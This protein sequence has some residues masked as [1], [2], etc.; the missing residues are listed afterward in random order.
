[1]ATKANSKL[2]NILKYQRAFHIPQRRRSINY[3]DIPLQKEINQTMIL[4][5]IDVDTKKE[6]KL[7]LLRNGYHLKKKT[8]I[9]GIRSPVKIY[10]L[11]RGDGKIKFSI[12]NKKKWSKLSDREQK[13]AKQAALGDAI[14]NYIK[15]YEYISQYTGHIVS[16]NMF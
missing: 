11:Y 3:V 13:M 12:T 9:G 8:Y 4:N 6:M 5:T 2:S 7:T 14:S 16:K 1:M 10:C 15:Y